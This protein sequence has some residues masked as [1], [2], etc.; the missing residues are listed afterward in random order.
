M[1]P[2]ASSVP[3]TDSLTDCEKNVDEI[4]FKVRDNFI[5]T[6]YC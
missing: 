4:P 6:N 5:F 2:L 1:P 3:V